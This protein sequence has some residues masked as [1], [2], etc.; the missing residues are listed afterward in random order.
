M[1]GIIFNDKRRTNTPS[2]QIQSCK[3]V[4]DLATEQRWPVFHN[5]AYHSDS[6]PAGSRG[7]NPIFLTPY[8]RDYVVG[9]F[10]DVA[11]EFLHAVKIK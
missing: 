4:A 5:E 3:D 7:G 11:E 6:Y 1:A 9:E 2:E 8:A 10:R